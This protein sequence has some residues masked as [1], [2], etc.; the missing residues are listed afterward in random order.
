MSKEGNYGR[1]WCF[2]RSYKPGVAKAP[3]EIKEIFELFS[4]NGMMSVHHLQRF[5]T[6]VQ[7]EDDKV[8]KDEAEAVME[9]FNLKDHKQ[10][11]GLNLE[12][13]FRYL[14][15]DINSPLP[16]PPK[17]KKTLSLSDVWDEKRYHLDSSVLI[18]RFIYY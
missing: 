16:C 18:I 12:A 5:M 6:V 9:A 2:R 4:E 17:V 13:F 15:G 8:T 3:A 14:L 11:K 10:C 1:C 7:G